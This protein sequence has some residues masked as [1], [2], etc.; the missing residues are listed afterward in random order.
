MF[1]WIIYI[2]DISGLRTWLR[3]HLHS[4]RKNS[5]YIYRYIYWICSGVYMEYMINIH[6]EIFFEFWA[7]SL[8]FLQGGVGILIIFPTKARSIGGPLC[9]NT[10]FFTKSIPR[11]NIKLVVSMYLPAFIPHAFCVESLL[12]SRYV[13]CMKYR[14]QVPMRN[15]KPD[16]ILRS[17]NDQFINY[18]AATVIWYSWVTS[19]GYLPVVHFLRQ[20][21]QVTTIPCLTKPSGA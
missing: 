16:H 15:K 12:K 9:E 5:W 21:V 3:L 4:F 13:S 8:L 6:A 20:G 7:C 1:T 10:F 18:I 11:G 17:T 2:S 19:T 14:Y